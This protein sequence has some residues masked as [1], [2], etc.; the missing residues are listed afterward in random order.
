M[1]AILI[2]FLSVIGVSFAQAGTL[3]ACKDLSQSR[4]TI[5]ETYNKDKAETYYF[6]NSDS[7]RRG[8]SQRVFFGEVSDEKLTIIETDAEFKIERVDVYKF[9]T[10]TK[11]LILNKENGNAVYEHKKETEVYTDIVRR[12]NLYNCRDQRNR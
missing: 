2:I 12:D 4:R 7:F 3:F 5:S 8:N 9:I 6:L 11:S 1:K 10:D